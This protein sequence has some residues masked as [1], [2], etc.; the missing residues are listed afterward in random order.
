MKIHEL[1]FEIRPS[2]K[3]KGQVQEEVHEGSKV[4]STYVPTAHP[5]QTEKLSTG[6]TCLLIIEIWLHLA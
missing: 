3:K 4:T 1:A 6:L 2:Q 5:S